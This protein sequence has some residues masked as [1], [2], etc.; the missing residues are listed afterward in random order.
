MGW[1]GKR[2][3]SNALKSQGSVSQPRFPRKKKKKPEAKIQIKQSL[4]YNPEQQE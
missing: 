2:T 3:I 1:M 4:D